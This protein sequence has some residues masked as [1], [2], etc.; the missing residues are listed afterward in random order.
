M[1]S[2]S[3]VVDGSPVGPVLVADTYWTR[4]RGMLGRRTLPA[5]LL[6][7]PANSVHGMG[8]TQPL[9]VAVLDAAGTVLDVRVLR[10]M[11]M[12]RAVSGGRQVLEAPAGSFVRW[13]VRPG[14]VVAT[15]A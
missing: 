12:T 3:L 5:A 1:R 8:M 14:S 4:L 6:L 13:G 2:Q 11:R 10:P 15:S 9:D 7:T